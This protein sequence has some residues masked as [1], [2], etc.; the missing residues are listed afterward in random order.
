MAMSSRSHKIL[1]YKRQGLTASSSEDLGSGIILFALGGSLCRPTLMAGG[2]PIPPRSATTTLPIV[3]FDMSS[4]KDTFGP[5][6]ELAKARK[7]GAE[8]E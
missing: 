1:G 6:P 4:A 8:S 7:N 3:G 5:K 2:Q